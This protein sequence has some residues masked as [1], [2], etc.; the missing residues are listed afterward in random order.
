M[1][2]AERLLDAFRRHGVKSAYGFVNGKKVAD[3]PQSEA[4]LR[5][6]REAGHPLG[7]HT[8]S[9]ANLNTSGLAEYL[10]DL[11]KGEEILAKLDVDP[12]IAKVFRYPFLFEGD[13]HEKR[14]GVRRYLQEH[15]YI[16]APVTIDADDWAFN[17]PFSRC[18][19]RNDA[20]SLAKL[21]R[22]F[23][24]V[25]V[26]ELRRMREL[27]QSLVQREAPQVLLLHIGAADA[28]AIDDLLVAYEKE[29]AQWIDL[30]AALADP[31]FA[32]DSGAPVRF[33]AALP[34]RIARARGVRTKVPI[35]ARDLEDDLARICRTP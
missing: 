16:A 6:W 33:G 13:T 34:Y 1:A 2:I 19:A 24:E 29:G 11:E 27:S 20:A 25:H 35:F 17:P 22:R 12:R 28:D 5:R 4:I 8:Y 3:E 26:D 30:R 31:Y 18:A 7:N 9:H 23:V 14:D 32:L 15:G 10:S 21:R